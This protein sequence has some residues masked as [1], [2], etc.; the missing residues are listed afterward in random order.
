MIL[1][2]FI[3]WVLEKKIYLSSSMVRATQGCVL[4]RG[5]V[6]FA[7]E[8]HIVLIFSRLVSAMLFMVREWWGDSDFDVGTSQNA[9]FIFYF[10]FVYFSSIFYTTF[11]LIK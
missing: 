10:F 2:L 1:D 5:L 4:K 11:F 3:H 8:P 6:N 9:F 7:G